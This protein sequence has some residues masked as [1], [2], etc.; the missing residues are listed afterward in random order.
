M[1]KNAS[2]SPWHTVSATQALL[3]QI[4]V[5]VAH[6]PGHPQTFWLSNEREILRGRSL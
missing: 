1:C 5:F 3:M 6:L 2:N 4:T